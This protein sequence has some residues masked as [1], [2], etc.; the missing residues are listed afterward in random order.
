MTNKETSTRWG[1][2]WQ[3]VRNFMWKEKE[4]PPLRP[5]LIQPVQ[6]SL[7]EAEDFVVEYLQARLGDNLA[8]C[9]VTEVR[10]RAKVMLITIV[11]EVVPALKGMKEQDLQTHLEERIDAEAGAEV[12]KQ[13]FKRQ[14]HMFV[15]RE[16]KTFTEIQ[17]AK[18]RHRP[19]DRWELTVRIFK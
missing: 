12:I 4:H 3:G 1:K 17:Q 8:S 18:R 9:T 14:S 7:G 11:F 2:F 16:L 6:I 19:V 10:D 13:R 5:L 15:A